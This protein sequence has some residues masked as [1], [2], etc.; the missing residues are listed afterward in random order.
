[1]TIILARFIPIVR[2]FAPI[3]AGIGKMNYKIFLA[4]NIIGGILW[5]ISLTLAGFFLSKIIPDIEEHLSLVI[6]I[7]IAISVIPPILHLLKEK[8]IAKKENDAQA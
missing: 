2:T 1:M 3:V 4:Y 7:I 5:T 8:Y 6:G